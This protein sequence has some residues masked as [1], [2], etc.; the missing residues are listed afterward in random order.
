MSYFLEKITL[1]SLISLD[2]Q[3][4]P[5]GKF[6]KVIHHP[7]DKFLSDIDFAEDKLSF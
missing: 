1:S 3:N 6:F 5:N 4:I 2:I 7:L